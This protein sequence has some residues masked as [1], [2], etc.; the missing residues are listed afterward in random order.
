MNS[1]VLTAIIG[2][3]ILLV[4]C[5]F[6]GWLLILACGLL[7]AIGV[8]ELG[9]LFE[10]RGFSVCKPLDML[11]ALALVAGAGLLRW[12]VWPAAIALLLVAVAYAI[13]AQRGDAPLAQGLAQALGVVYIGSGFGALLALR[14]GYPSW[15]LILLAFLNV[16]ITDITAYEIGRRYGKSKLAPSV[17]PNKTWE[18]ALAGLLVSTLFCGIYMA[19]VLHIRLDRSI[20]LA[21][22]FSVVAQ[23]G[24]LLES[25]LKRWAGVKDSGYLFP[26]HGGVLDRFDSLLLSAPVILL[27]I[28]FF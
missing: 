6:G 3:P 4:C 13:Y 10:D 28:G 20:T 24:D 8:V 17:S 2:V 7:A 19:I 1:R 23:L 12:A 16:W 14:L 5:Y 11:A 21:A 18:G 22:L 9:R 26:G 15:V 27:L 25:A